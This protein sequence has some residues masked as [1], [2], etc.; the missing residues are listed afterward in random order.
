MAKGSSPEVY[1]DF[2]SWFI[3]DF[4]LMQNGVASIVYVKNKNKNQLQFYDV[5]NVTFDLVHSDDCSSWIAGKNKP[6][7]ICIFISLGG[8]NTKSQSN[9]KQPILVALRFFQG[10]S[11]SNGLKLGFITVQSERT[12]KNT[13]TRPACLVRAILR[14]KEATDTKLPKIQNESIVSDYCLHLHHSLTRSCLPIEQ[15]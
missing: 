11:Y 3:Y 6:S 5:N 15:I 8:D 9:K 13:I 2:Y 10:I 12:N 14:A 1:A 7:S 4:R